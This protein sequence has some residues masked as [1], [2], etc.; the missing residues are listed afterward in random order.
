MTESDGAVAR[1]AGSV[2]PSTRG[3]AGFTLIEGLVVIAILAIL[4]S[5][6]AFAVNQ[7]SKDSEETACR[8]ER[9]T[10]ETA[11]WAAENTGR[12][13]DYFDEYLSNSPKYFSYSG[14]L[15]AP[16]WGPGPEH[17]GGACPATIPVP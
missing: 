7:V 5:I 15:A 1:A 9:R 14:T 10:I 16:V 6:A 8:A 11:M 2:A 12:Q 17:P 13:N 4:A 3:Q